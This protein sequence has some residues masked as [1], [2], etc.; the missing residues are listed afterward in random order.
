ARRA[1]PGGRRAVL[2]AAPACRLPDRGR[3]R[4]G[5]RTLLRP[6]AVAARELPPGGGAARTG[7]GVS[8]PPLGASDDSPRAP[9]SPAHRPVARCAAHDAAPGLDLVRRRARVGAVRHR[10]M[11]PSPAMVR[12][13]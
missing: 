7:A 11:C 1:G 8:A 10:A 9:A 2:V 4:R 5:R 3:A 6:A 13:T 12:R